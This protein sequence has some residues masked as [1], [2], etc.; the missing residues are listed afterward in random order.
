[1]RPCKCAVL[2]VI[3]EAKTQW[4]G[5]GVPRRLRQDVDVLLNKRIILSFVYILTGYYV[6][7]TVSSSHS[8]TEAH[9]EMKDVNTQLEIIRLAA[10]VF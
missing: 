10:V 1:M 7:N 4:G 9:N 5:N 8:Y 3:P 2:Q 6:C